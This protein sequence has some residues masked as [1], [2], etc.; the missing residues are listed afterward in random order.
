MQ[1]EM[2]PGLFSFEVEAQYDKMPDFRILT[3]EN[4]NW[5]DEPVTYR[6]IFLKGCKMA[7][8]LKQAGIGNG[9]RFS[10]IMKNHPEMIYAMVA[11][12]LTGA[13]IVP[14]DP[15]SKGNKLSYQIRDSNSKGIIFTNEY[16]GEVAKSLQ[17]LPDVKVIGVV[18][19]P[20]FET[21]RRDQYPDLGAIL[22]VPDV[23]P[24]ED[25]KRYHNS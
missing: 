10:V 8:A 6:D 24:S 14:I 20:G 22:Y 1:Q 4:G 19:K 18:Y 3:F 25:R 5:P 9:D 15:R 7:K 13:V 11:A 23:P 21:P 16:A 2:V 17:E 12:S